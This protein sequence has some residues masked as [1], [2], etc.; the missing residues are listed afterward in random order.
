MRKFLNMMPVWALLW[1]L[2]RLQNGVA[3]PEH[4]CWV[5][6]AVRLTWCM[7][8]SFPLLEKIKKK[9]SNAIILQK[10]NKKKRIIQSQN[11]VPN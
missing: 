4:F 6:Y 3:N 1:L 2:Y 9:K 10:Y 8:T 5:V 11:I 7:K